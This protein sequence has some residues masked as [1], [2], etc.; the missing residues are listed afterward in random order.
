MLLDSGE[1]VRSRC[2]VITTGTFLR[3]CINTGLDVRP[4]G[5]AGDE[6][7]IGLATSL[8]EAGFAMGRLKTGEKIALELRLNIKKMI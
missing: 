4:A 8:E 7:A 1:M 2:V 3:G 5:R 6:P